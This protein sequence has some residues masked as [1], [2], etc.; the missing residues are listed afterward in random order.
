MKL[1]EAVNKAERF[2]RIKLFPLFWR[3]HCIVFVFFWP[4]EVYL[5]VR[6]IEIAGEHNSVIELRVAKDDIGKVIESDEG[7]HAAL[8]ADFARKFN[9]TPKVVNAIAAIVNATQA[10]GVEL[11]DVHIEEPSL[12][13]LFL[14]HTGRS[15]RD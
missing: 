4:S 5:C 3:E 11:R 13:T 15:L 10:A 1:S 2:H 14:H 12:E 7:N 8:G 9:E 6:N